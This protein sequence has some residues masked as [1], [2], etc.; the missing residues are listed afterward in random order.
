MLIVLAS[1][2][3]LTSAIASAELM[4][5]DD[6]AILA[7]GLKAIH[8]AMVP[9]KL[10]PMLT[11]GTRLLTQYY[12]TLRQ[13]CETREFELWTLLKRTMTVATT[14]APGQRRW[15]L[16]SSFSCCSLPSFSFSPALI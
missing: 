6:N 12:D 9:D 1:S 2:S 7:E 11:E 3:M 14:N 16:V 5:Q 10:A 4:T 13:E 8:G 15:L